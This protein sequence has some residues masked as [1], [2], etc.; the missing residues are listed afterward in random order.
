MKVR[1][2]KHVL[3]SV[4]ENHDALQSFLQQE[5]I[6]ESAVHTMT[7][8]LYIASFW[9]ADAEKVLKWL[10]EQGASLVE[11]IK[12]PTNRRTEQKPY[13]P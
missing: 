3:I 4:Y 13:T 10:H 2:S 12:N 7:P 11:N 1:V 5:D 6:Y 8:E 9:P